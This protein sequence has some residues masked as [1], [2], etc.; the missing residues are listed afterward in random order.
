MPPSGR[1]ACSPRGSMSSSMIPPCR[2]RLRSGGPSAQRLGLFPGADLSRLRVSTDDADISTGAPRPGRRRRRHRPPSG[3]RARRHRRDALA[4]RT[5]PPPPARRAR[6]RRRRTSG[7][8]AFYDSI[9][10]APAIDVQ[11]GRGALAARA[12]AGGAD[13]RRPRRD[14]RRHAVAAAVGQRRRRGARR[15]RGPPLRRPGH[16]SV[17]VPATE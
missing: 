12:G 3:W 13:R 14:H 10:M 11:P 5:D 7:S 15:A 6:R 17:A 8:H 1:H 4:L 2:Q 9:G 16:P